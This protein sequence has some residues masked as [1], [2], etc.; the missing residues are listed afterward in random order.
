MKIGFIGTGAIAE[1]V[2]VGLINHGGVSG[3]VLISART[4]ARAEKLSNKFENVKVEPDNQSI[5]DKVE[6]LFLSVLPEQANDVMNSLS[7]RAEQTIVSLVAGI[8]VSEIVEHVTPA[9]QVHR[10]IPMPPNELG[11]G[12]IPIFPPSDEVESLLSDLGSIIPVTDEGQFS[13]FS[14]ASALMAVFFELVATNARWCTRQG[15]SAEQGTLYSSSLFHA[16]ATLT[17]EM[18]PEKLQQLSD[19]CLTAGGL[20]EQILMAAKTHGLFGLLEQELDKVLKRISK[21]RK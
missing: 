3:P 1:A 15:V 8:S 9:T 6:I 14:A 13:T 16:L 11:V 17:R 4:A 18:G 19:E 5:V 20:N 7:F 12:P 10:I 21:R 2:I